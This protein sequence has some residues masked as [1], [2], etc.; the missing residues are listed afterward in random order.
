VNF[1]Q[2]FWSC[3]NKDLLTEGFGWMAPEYNLMS[4]ALS[5]LHLKKYYPELQL[6]ADGNSARILIDEL[7][8]PYA[9]L[10]CDLDRLNGYPP[11]LWALPK[12]YAYSV[13]DSPFLSIDG[14]AYLWEPLGPDLLKGELIAQNLEADPNFYN[15]LLDHVLPHLSFIPEEIA[16]EISDCKTIKAYNAGMLGG[17]DLAFFSEYTQKAFEFVDK[18]AG[19]LEKLANPAINNLY[20][21]HLFY[22]LAKRQNKNVSVFIPEVIEDLRYPGF[23]DFPE[24]PHN[25]KYLHLHGQYKKSRVICKQLANRLR[26]DYP[27]YYY[28]IIHLF[29]R[30][31]R[32]MLDKTYDYITEGSE[33]GLVKRFYLLKHGDT[34]W[35]VAPREPAPSFDPW[36]SN[37]CRQFLQNDQEGHCPVELRSRLLTDISELEC[38]I[39][40]I[41][42]VDFAGVDK[43]RLYMADMLTVSS[44]ENLFKDKDAIGRQQL[45]AN[46]Y[47]RVK[48]TEFNW[49]LLEDPGGSPS[50]LFQSIARSGDDTNY[51][52]VVPEIS[53]DRYVL[54][55][56]DE[57]DNIL[58]ESLKNPC[59]VGDLIDRLAGEFD[60]AE[61]ENS[62]YEEL[63]SLV[64]GRIK[65]GLLTKT[66]ELVKPLPERQR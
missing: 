1:F 8:L 5:C 2:T 23:A 49:S 9:E 20:E 40:H 64:Y 61:L 33:E 21:Q 41:V 36:R 54:Y 46:G 26:N 42:K 38:F 39:D 22:C 27:E 14:D 60:P 63:Q 19:D 59:P 30:D 57:L 17:S 55:G 4:W 15:I 50:L 47:C 28:R 34:E 29:K 25:K 16:R 32:P 35:K 44:L 18:N 12:L 24:V 66:I 10:H 52:I 3:N 58:L 65:N 37:S 6:Y 7:K 56:G 51:A 43:E 13:Q 62:G 53:G 45:I 31:R 48:P 11:Y